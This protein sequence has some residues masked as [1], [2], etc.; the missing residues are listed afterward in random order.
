MFWGKHVFAVAI[1]RP[2]LQ[3]SKDTREVFSSFCISPR[4]RENLSGLFLWLMPKFK[5][6]ILY[7][8]SRSCP[9][10]EVAQQ[11]TLIRTYLKSVA[12]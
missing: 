7:T 1:W 6:I 9:N 2:T 10:C 3:I 12:S 8:F 4:Y 5:C 11:I